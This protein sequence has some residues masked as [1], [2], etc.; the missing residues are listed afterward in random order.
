MTLGF[1]PKMLG[2]SMAKLSLESVIENKVKSSTFSELELAINATHVDK[3]ALKIP[4][5]YKGFITK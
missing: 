5:K 1:A 4:E 2:E 3:F